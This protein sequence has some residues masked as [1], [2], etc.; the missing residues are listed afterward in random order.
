MRS[1]RW[2]VETLSIF[3]GYLI[4]QL[5]GTDYPSSRET[6]GKEDGGI[7]EEFQVFSNLEGVFFSG[8]AVLLYKVP[9]VDH[10]HAS[11]GFFVDKP[12]YLRILFRHTLSRIDEKECHITSIDGF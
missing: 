5:D 8:V 10:D 3:L 2:E 7:R 6:G 4:H 12:S 1:F 9:L 11:L